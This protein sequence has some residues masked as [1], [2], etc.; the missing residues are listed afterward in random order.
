MALTPDQAA[1]QEYAAWLKAYPDRWAGVRS[2]IN[3]EA[4]AAEQKRLG[5][6]LTY[7]ERR[8]LSERVKK[9]QFLKR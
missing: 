3:V 7:A 2:T 6:D 9:E 1:A 4:V 8:Q 5:R